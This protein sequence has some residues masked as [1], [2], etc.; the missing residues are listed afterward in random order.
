MEHTKGIARLECY[1]EVIV[2][3]HTR[4]CHVITQGGIVS[5]QKEPTQND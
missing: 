2:C 1:D 3:D 5:E 4:L